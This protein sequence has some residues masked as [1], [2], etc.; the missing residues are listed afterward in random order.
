M[1]RGDLSDVDVEPGAQRALPVRL[2]GR[3]EDFAEENSPVAFT[4]ETLD[5][6]RYRV[7]TTSRFV[8]PADLD[9]VRPENRR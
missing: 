8:R 7:T 9:Y 4:I 3:F 2:V 5:E 1:A 6:P